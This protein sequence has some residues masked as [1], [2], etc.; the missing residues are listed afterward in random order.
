MRILFDAYWLLTGPPSGR[1]VVK[2]FVSA[3]AEEFPQDELVLAVPKKERDQI[4]AD[5]FLS[6]GASYLFITGSPH[7]LSV[8]LTLDSRGFDAV[9]SQNFAPRRSSALGVVFV[10]D[11]M[12]VRHPRWFSFIERCYLT[13]SLLSLRRCDLIV[14]SSQSEA[15]HVRSALSK[16]TRASVTAVGLGLSSDFSSATA[17]PPPGFDD[18]SSFIL[19]VGRLNVRKNVLFC[20]KSLLDGAVIS[21]SFPLVVVGQPDGVAEDFADIQGAILDGSVRFTAYVSDAELKWLYGKASAF[22]FPSLDEGF[23]L[24][25]LEALSCGAS[26]ALS[27]IPPFR[28]V[29]PFATFFDPRDAASIQAA[30]TRAIDQSSVDRRQTAGEDWSSVVGATRSAI[31]QTRELRTK[32]EKSG[33]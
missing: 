26:L 14:T 31:W 7:G 30:V 28:E 16:R 11:V 10:H 19:A 22:V 2:S 12:F 5:S 21:P 25:I 18:H 9:I 33:T 17:L 27:D 6:D 29:A 8:L 32:G 4:L 20:A 1:N 13:V 24:P 15:R 3:W 23:G